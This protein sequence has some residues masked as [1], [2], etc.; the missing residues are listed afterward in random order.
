MRVQRQIE[1]KLQVAFEPERLAIVN[2]SGN[3]NVPEG[4]E[5]HFNAIIVSAAF[6]DQN[7]VQR[8]RAVYGAIGE[9]LRTEIHAFTMKTL[10]P[11]E[12]EAAG[13]E[14]EN[15]APK[16]RGGAKREG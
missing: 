5:S 7:L 11:A 9:E 6:E 15:P 16:C 3:H 2:E 1:Q 10:T 13:G 4:S 12:W 8:H 14:A